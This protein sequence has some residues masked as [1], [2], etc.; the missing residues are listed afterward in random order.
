MILLSP[1]CLKNNNQVLQALMVIRLPKHH[2][3][4]LIPASEMFHISVTIIL[5]NMVVELS[6]VQKNG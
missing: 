2:C 6:S 3:E 4:H 5:V 1:M